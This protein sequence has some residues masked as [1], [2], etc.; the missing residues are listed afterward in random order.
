MKT[1]VSERASE[2]VT[3]RLFYL[4]E[5]KKKS[6]KCERPSGGGVSGRS[7]KACFSF[8]IYLNDT[9]FDMAIPLKTKITTQ[10]KCHTSAYT[11]TL[12]QNSDS[13]RKMKW[14]KPG[15]CMLWC[16]RVFQVPL[17]LKQCSTAKVSGAKLIHLSG[18]NC[19]HNTIYKIQST[20]LE[21]TVSSLKTADIETLVKEARPCSR[22][23]MSDAKLETH[24]KGSNPNSKH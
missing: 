4:R 20:G 13:T 10:Q 1:D 14:G 8:F 23:M 2:W 11:W 6:G 5:G 22:C 12:I 21:P 18:F 3:D 17:L 24:K 15:S 16:C 9:L 7:C 19:K